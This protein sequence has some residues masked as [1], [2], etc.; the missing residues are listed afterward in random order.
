MGAAPA[1]G[2]HAAALANPASYTDGD[3]NP[4]INTH[5]RTVRHPCS[6]QYRASDGA[7]AAR[8]ERHTRAIRHSPAYG[9]SMSN[10]HPIR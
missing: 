4:N 3:T 2:Q 6:D 10:A 9:L 5:H 7:A 1:S 8:A